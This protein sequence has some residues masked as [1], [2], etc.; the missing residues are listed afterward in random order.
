VTTPNLSLGICTTH[1]NQSALANLLF[2]HRSPCKFARAPPSRDGCWSCLHGHIGPPARPNEGDPA[3]VAGPLFIRDL[4]FR[5]SVQLLF[6]P[7]LCFLLFHVLDFTQLLCFIEM[8]LA[9]KMGVKY[10][11]TSTNVRAAST[12][13]SFKFAAIVWFLTRCFLSNPPR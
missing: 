10:F 5:I 13:L 7:H 3:D 12:I 9:F 11:R 4:S 8:L 6:L 1:T 2:P